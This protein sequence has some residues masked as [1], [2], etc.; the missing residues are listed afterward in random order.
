MNHKK[1]VAAIVSM[2]TA[3]TSLSMTAIS[4]QAADSE[5]EM[6]CYRSY[7]KTCRLDRS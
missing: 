2:V 1:F 5:E 7:G 3:A 4:G 6:Q